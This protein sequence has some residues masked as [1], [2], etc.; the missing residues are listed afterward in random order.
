MLCM[1]TRVSGHPAADT[2]RTVADTADGRNGAKS[3]TSSMA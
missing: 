1:H 2:G 3:V